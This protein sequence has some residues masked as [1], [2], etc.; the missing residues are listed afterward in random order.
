[1]SSN[2]VIK[3]ISCK[4][5]RGSASM[6]VEN[7]G[8]TTAKR[9]FVCDW[10]DRTQFMYNLLGY[11][12]VDPDGKS[13]YISPLKYPGRYDLFCKNVNITGYGKIIGCDAENPQYEYAKIEASYD[14]SGSGGGGAGGE[15]EDEVEKVL[16]T[17]ETTYGSEVIAF[18]GKNF[19]WDYPY[20]SLLEFSKI[21]EKLQTYK[22]VP[23]IEHTYTKFKVPGIPYKQ[24]QKAGKINNAEFSGAKKGCLLFLG[25]TTTPSWDAKT[26]QIV[27][28][29]K[30]KFKERK[31][32]DWNMFYNTEFDI[33][34]YIQNFDG[35]RYT[36]YEEDDF[37]YLFAN[38]DPTEEEE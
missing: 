30:Y 22:L 24:L 17:L 5:L 29:I 28:T 12:T 37:T 20:D 36:P 31:D 2:I 23:T 15:E 9:I 34:C 32:Y 8:K 10:E 35:E 27:H 26:E 14:N 19:Y 21:D 3:G 18:D 6:T 7:S 33:W 16:N 4:E 13:I 11:S 25:A 38:N 1:M